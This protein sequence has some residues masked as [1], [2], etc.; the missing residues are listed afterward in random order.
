MDFY[1]RDF[2]RILDF[3]EEELHYMLKTAKRL[4]QLKHEGKAHKI[5]PNKNIAILF[6]KTSTR[7]RCSFE[8][9][10][11]DLGMGVTYLD[12]TG[13][14]MGHKESIADTARVLS[15]FYDGIEYRGFDQKIVDDLAKYAD[16]PVWNGLTDECHPTQVL[17]DFMT[18]EEH[19]GQLKGLTL[20]FVGDARNN[21]AN[22]LMAM[23][24]KMGVNYIACGPKELRPSDEIVAQCMPIAEKNGCTIT[25]TDD[26]A[27]L[28]GK[29]DAIY[30]DVWLSMGEDKEKWGERIEQLKPYQV[31]M[32]LMNRAKPTAVF[33]HALPSFHDLSTS[34]ARDV[35]EKFGISEMEVTNEVFESERSIVFDEAENR[36]HTIKAVMFLTLYKK[37]EK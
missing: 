31:N 35:N 36:M 18:M 6:E 7:T 25:I 8:V 26:L 34:V 20:A 32:E 17:A 11:Y 28:D 29:A 15:R 1:G 30:A 24:A 10:G 2:L 14:Q 21:V 23:S 33:L 3:S 37:E 22:S 4:K 5:F 27:E 9:A 12:P 13:S 16:V 19:F